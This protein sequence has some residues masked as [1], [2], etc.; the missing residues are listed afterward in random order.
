[1]L[2]II[3]LA[4]RF[5]LLP[6]VYASLPKHDDICW[7]LSIAKNRGIPNESFIIKDKRIIIHQIDCKDDDFV[8]KR[9]KVFEKIKDGYFYMLDDDTIFINEVYN[10]YKQHYLKK[11]NVLIIGNEIIRYYKTEGILKANPLSEDPSKVNIG[12][13]MA[14]SSS[15]V[16]RFVKW[17]WVPQGETYSRDFLFWSNCFRFFGEGKTINCN[18]IIS[19][20]NYFSPV[21]RI[22]IHKKIKVLGNFRLHTDIDNVIIAKIY[23]YITYSYLALKSKLYMKRKKI[24]IPL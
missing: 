20:H 23:N 13:G 17:E 18:K 10:Q 9:N 11:E 24:K 16:L 8:T 15:E 6:K 4:Y 12:T 22:R 5:E 3:T 19:Y 1:M 14:L 7:H 21:L 2:H